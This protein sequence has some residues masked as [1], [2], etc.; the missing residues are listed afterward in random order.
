MIFFNKIPRLDNNISKCLNRL[1]DLGLP[2]V[3]LLSLSR[4]HVRIELI[5]WIIYDPRQLGQDASSK[6]I[7][8]DIHCSPESIDKPINSYYDRVHPCNREIDGVTN[9]HHQYQRGG[10]DGSDSD[11]GESR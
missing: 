9:H 1:S 3:H 6:Q 11:R 7:P 8:R 10:W 2:L 5:L 4:G